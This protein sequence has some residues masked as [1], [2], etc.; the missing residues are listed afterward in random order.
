MINEQAP[1][2]R[3]EDNNQITIT[4]GEGNGV[5]R[6]INCNLVIGNYFLKGV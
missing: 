6:L 1:I 4:K 2:T 5:F 3:D